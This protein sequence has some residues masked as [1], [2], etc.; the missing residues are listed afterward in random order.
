MVASRRPDAP[1]ARGGFVLGWVG[2]VLVLLALIA[3]SLWYVTTTVQANVARAAVGQVYLDLCISALS[4][5]AASLNDSVLEDKPY[6]GLK[7]REALGRDFPF[8]EK[9]FEPKRTIEMAAKLYP[10]VKVGSVAIRP[11]DRTSPGDEDPLLGAMEMKVKCEGRL[12]GIA[13]GREI[14][15]RFVFSVPCSTNMLAGDQATY[16]RIHWGRPILYTKPVASRVLR[17]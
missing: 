11:V 17:L 4:E 1:R 2:G 8:D 5:A 6:L 15:H 9:T 3:F 7:V 12:G 16:M 13:T 14:T 10:D